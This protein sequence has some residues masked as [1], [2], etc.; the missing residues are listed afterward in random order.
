ML[1]IEFTNDFKKI[2]KQVKQLGGNPVVTIE[3][4][5]VKSLSFRTEKE[6]EHTYYKIV[7]TVSGKKLIHNKYP[8]YYE[9][10][11]VAQ[12]LEFELSR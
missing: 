6:V 3:K 11:W 8:A 1:F 7:V 10:L 9:A 4:E 2:K 12:N 5:I